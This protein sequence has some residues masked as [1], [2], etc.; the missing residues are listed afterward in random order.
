MFDKKKKKMNK[1]TNE[2]KVDDGQTSE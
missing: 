2:G 1:W